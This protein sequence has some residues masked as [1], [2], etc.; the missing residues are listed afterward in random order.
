MKMKIL[1]LTVFIVFIAASCY[2]AAGNDTVNGG[3]LAFRINA[4]M[5]AHGAEA[6]D[7]GELRIKF[8]D[9]SD[10]QEGKDYEI[11]TLNDFPKISYLK[12]PAPITVNGKKTTI[13][14]FGL[15][16]NETPNS[17]TTEIDLIPAGVSLRALVE[18]INY[19]EEYSFDDS[20][21][22]YGQT[23]YI[24]HAGVSEPFTVKKDSSATVE[25]PL[26]YAAPGIVL[27]DMA[28]QDQNPDYYVSVFFM[29]EEDFDSIYYIDN[30]RIRSRSGG[31]TVYPIYYYK[32]ISKY[33]GS[34]DM[35]PGKKLKLMIIACEATDSPYAA[36]LSQ[37][38]E[39]APGLPQRVAV[40]WKYTANFC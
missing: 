16:N 31:G 22:S 38:F 34:I 19:K 21:G 2:Q 23:A 32:S 28:L 1:L 8:F 14:Y 7:A 35:L 29:S 12:K 33:L 18:Y 6:G 27:M 24:S 36:A 10:M 11:N 13:S 9:A 4:P 26:Y 3:S 37:T 5:R 15:Y 39:L 20:Y 17:G 30:N 40:D 25:I